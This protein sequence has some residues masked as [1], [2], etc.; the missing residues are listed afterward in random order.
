MHMWPAP[1]L[2]VGPVLRGFVTSCWHSVSFRSMFCWHRLGCWHRLVF[3]VLREWLAAVR[4]R[5]NVNPKRI[6]GPQHQCSVFVATSQ[7]KFVYNISHLQI[8]PQQVITDKRIDKS[9]KDFTERQTIILRM[10]PTRYCDSSYPPHENSTCCVLQRGDRVPPTTWTTSTLTITQ[11]LSAI[12][13]FQ[14]IT[15][16]AMNRKTSRILNTTASRKPTHAPPYFNR[17]ATSTT[18][19]APAFAA[20]IVYVSENFR[21]WTLL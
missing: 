14:G 12:F 1:Y 8:S 16:N 6:H 9:Q 2:K 3:A 17:A 10:K 13:A 11:Q 7:T 5:I 15:N 4:G 21:W 18:A 19:V 20:V